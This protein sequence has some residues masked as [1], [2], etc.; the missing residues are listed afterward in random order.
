MEPPLS[1]QPSCRL[2]GHEEHVF[3]YC[4]A[5]LTRSPASIE[6]EAAASIPLLC[7]CQPHRPNGIYD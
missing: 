4:H 1:R 6:D 2:C 5:E 3:T 7:P